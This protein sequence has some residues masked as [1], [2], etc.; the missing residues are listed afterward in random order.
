M[1]MVERAMGAAGVKTTR[2]SGEGTP[3]E[4]AERI[5]QVVKKVI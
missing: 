1:L 4:V 3:E 2:V 5:W